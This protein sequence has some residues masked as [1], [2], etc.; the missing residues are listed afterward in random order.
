M[1]GFAH[2]MDLIMILLEELEKDQR[3][4]TVSYTHLRAHETREDL[5]CR[6]LL[7]KKSAIRVGTGEGGRALT[8][9]DYMPKVRRRLLA[10]WV[11]WGARLRR[12][13]G[14]PPTRRGV[15][16][17]LAKRGE[18]RSTARSVNY[19]HLLVLGPVQQRSGRLPPRPPGPL[20]V[21]ELCLGTASAM[22]APL[23]GVA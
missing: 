22:A 9:G 13:P 4:G 8:T 19:T 5:V 1:D 7:E 16:P 6:L 11:V 10:A 18:A 3:L 17:T 23:W 15:G 20:R 12:G 14:A 2:A 21:W